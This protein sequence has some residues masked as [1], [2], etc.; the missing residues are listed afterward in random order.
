VRESRAVWVLRT[1]VV[2]LA[3]RRS[4]LSR[5]LGRIGDLGVWA[6][7]VYSPPIAAG[8]ALRR[9]VASLRTEVVFSY[10]D[11]RF[12]AV[13]RLRSNLV[14]AG[15]RTSP[16]STRRSASVQPT[17]RDLHVTEKIPGY[18]N[19]GDLESLWEADLL[20]GAVVELAG[21]TKSLQADVGTVEYNAQLPDGK[22]DRDIDGGVGY[23][24]RGQQ[25]AG[26]N[27]TATAIRERVERVAARF[28]FSVDSVAIFH[29]LGVAP[30]V[31]M[32][33]PNASTAV[34]RGRSLLDALVGLR[35]RY[36]GYYLELRDR[37]GKVASISSESYFTGTGR[38][39]P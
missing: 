31:V 29:A 11:G 33:A 28:G 7:I 6:P 17:I 5:P 19:G 12:V 30:A 10:K 8:S 22:V 20:T 2:R 13:R 24:A 18:K 26:A 36:E 9:V 35:P 39:G 34:S 14:S 32:T 15:I 37:H 38:G 1:A 4:C 23:V 3:V 27:D 16:P 21:K 25:F